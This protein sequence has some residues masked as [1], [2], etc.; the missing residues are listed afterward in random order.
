MAGRIDV[1]LYAKKIGEEWAR[2]REQ[3]ANDLANE[4]A[5]RLLGEAVLVVENNPH[6]KFHQH[7]VAL[8]ALQDKYNRR[9][10]ENTAW[11]LKDRPI[12]TKELGHE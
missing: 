6:H 4:M 8:Y 5:V 12:K 1:L 10:A 11:R 7:V 2:G 3:E 9:Q